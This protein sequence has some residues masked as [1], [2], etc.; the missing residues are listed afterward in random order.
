M[1][2]S[3]NIGQL[4]KKRNSDDVLGIVVES[5][6]GL[7]GNYSDTLIGVG[8]TKRFDEKTIE[9]VETTKRHFLHHLRRVIAEDIL[10]LESTYRCDC[11][12]EGQDIKLEDI[13]KRLTEIENDTLGKWY[14][15]DFNEK[16]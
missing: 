8:L 3:Y 9:V 6:H 11:V 4:V 10:S 13:D 2:G 15:G 16:S 5:S 14:W 7:G 12:V 1:L